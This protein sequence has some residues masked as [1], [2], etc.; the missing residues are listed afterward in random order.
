[1]AEI[2]EGFARQLHVAHLGDGYHVVQIPGEEGEPLKAWPGPF[3][4][5]RAAS[6]FRDDL[7]EAATQG[8][9]RDACCSDGIFDH[10][11]LAGRFLDL[12]ETHE[13]DARTLATM[14][15]AE[16][17]WIGLAPTRLDDT[18]IEF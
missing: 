8:N 10:F 13:G 17:P 18:G 16:R 11:N 5:E 9:P 6:L 2:R 15:A 7:I 1:M 12:I 4:S 3:K 14:I